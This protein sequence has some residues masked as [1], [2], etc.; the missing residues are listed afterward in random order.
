MLRICISWHE[1][2]PGGS[3]TQPA[4]CVGV[5][6]VSSGCFHPL[7][8]LCTA[9]VLAY[10]PL[11]TLTP[12]SFL[13]LLTVVYSNFSVYCRLQVQSAS[14]INVRRE[15]KSTKYSNSVYPDRSYFPLSL[16]GGHTL[17]GLR[18]FT[19]MREAMQQLI[20]KQKL[21]AVLAHVKPQSTAGALRST[22]GSL[23]TSKRKW[24]LYW[25]LRIV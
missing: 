7:E 8:E 5:C 19:A 12:T 21:A 1:R 25:I 9:C 14:A 20:I 2:N 11:E 23:D 16:W 4:V 10:P 24:H 6:A 18:S 3:C 22:C 13:P 15:P 17:L